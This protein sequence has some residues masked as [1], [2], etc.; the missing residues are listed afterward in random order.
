MIISKFRRWRWYK[1]PD[2]YQYQHVSRRVIVQCFR[3]AHASETRKYW[4]KSGDLYQLKSHRSDLDTVLVQ[5]AAV[6]H[7]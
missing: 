6:A 3:L 4:Y 1:S 7:F 5:A 2:L